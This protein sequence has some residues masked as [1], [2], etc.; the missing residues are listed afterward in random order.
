MRP[1]AEPASH[2]FGSSYQVRSRNRRIIFGSPL[3]LR[4]RIAFPKLFAGVHRPN[5]PARRQWRAGESA[6]LRCGLVWLEHA[7]DA[8]STRTSRFHTHTHTRARTSSPTTPSAAP[9][10]HFA[11]THKRARCPRLAT[12][13][14][15]STRSRVSGAASTLA[16]RARAPRSR[17]FPPTAPISPICRTPLFPHLTF[18]SRV[19][20]PPTTCSAASSLSSRR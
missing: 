14:W 11:Q 6:V 4:T 20:R 8:R 16:P 2:S 3:D 7:T 10:Q 17:L 13:A 18:Y 9:P 19:F 15:P 5:R 1:R 12:L